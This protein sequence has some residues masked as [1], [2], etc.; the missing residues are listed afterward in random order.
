VTGG[1]APQFN[2]A[3][4]LDGTVAPEPGAWILVTAGLGL[5]LLSRLRGLRD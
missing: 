5:V 3:F 4:S 1:A 2:T